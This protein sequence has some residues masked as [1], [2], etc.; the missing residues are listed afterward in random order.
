MENSWLDGF[1]FFI[2]EQDTA[3]GVSRGVAEAAVMV[4]GKKALIVTD[5]GVMDAGVVFPIVDLPHQRGIPTAIFTEVEANPRTETVY[6]SARLGYL[7][8]F[9]RQE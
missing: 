8:M 7:R 4:H 6:R 5:P 1:S 3:V 9:S 2:P